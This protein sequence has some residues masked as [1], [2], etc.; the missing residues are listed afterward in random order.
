MVDAS[1]GRSKEFLKVRGQFKLG[2]LVTEASHPA[3]ANLSE[4]AKQDTAAALKL[5][6]DVEDD[7]IRKFREFVESGRAGEIKETILHSLKNVGRIFSTGCGSTG[8]LSILLD[9]VWRDF[10]RQQARK[11]GEASQAKDRLE[12]LYAASYDKKAS[13]LKSSIPK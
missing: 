9:S 11:L 4:V 1:K 10:W 6:F 2:A 8:R 13:D 12:A 7:V 5:L 3:T